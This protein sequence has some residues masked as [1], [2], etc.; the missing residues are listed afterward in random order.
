M[1]GVGFV[2]LALAAASVVSIRYAIADELVSAVNGELFKADTARAA[3][4]LNMSDE[5]WQVLLAEAQSAV[6]LAPR[7]G[8][9]W[10][11]LARVR[12]LPRMVGEAAVSPDYVAIYQAYREA[13]LAQPSSAYAW[14]G[15]AY[16]SDHLFTQNRLPGGK[17]ALE[18][19]IE[20]TRILG[21]REP[22]ALRTVVDLGLAN[23]P[24]LTPATKQL[25]LGAVKHLAQRHRDEVV[26][27]AGRR[28]ALLT[29]C[30]EPAMLVHQGCN[31]YRDSATTKILAI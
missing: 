15:L 22:H 12:Y 7:N 23:W 21:Q 29:V 27:I 8:H 6:Q 30:A 25:V 26:A 31:K 5:T 14:S 17:A 19:A 3:T 9:H 24:L 16:A 10:N 1:L 4:G 11:A 2:L 18:Q 13:V 20:R 28:G